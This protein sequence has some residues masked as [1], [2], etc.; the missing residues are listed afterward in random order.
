MRKLLPLPTALAA[1]LL[2]ACAAPATTGAPGIQPRLASVAAAAATITAEAAY[3]H[4]AYLASD[5]MRGRATPSPELE[6]AAQYIAAQFEAAGLRPAG[7]DG[8]YFQRWPLRTRQPRA[9]GALFRLE[10]GGQSTAIAFGSDYFTLVSAQA[11]IQ[12]PP[13]YVGEATTT[14]RSIMIPEGSIPLFLIPGDDLDAH[15]EARASQALAAAVE[16]RAAAVVLILDPAVSRELVQA[17]AGQLSATRVLLPIF[18]VRYQAMAQLLSAAGHDLNT[19]RRSQRAE[20][21]GALLQLATPVASTEAQPPNVVALLPGSDSLLRHTY[22]VYSAHFD[23]VGVGTPDASGDSIYNGADD[24]ASGT[25]A[26]LQLA[27]A[28][29]SLPTPPRR[30]VLFV[31]VSGE[32]LGLLGSQYFVQNPTVPL[33][34]MVAN[35]NMDMVGRNHPDTVAAIGIGYTTLGPL[36]LAIAAALPE[37]GLVVTPDPWPQERLFFRSDHF[38]WAHRGVPAIFFTTGLHPQYH[39]PS[40][41]PEL[42]DADKLARITR[43]VFHL[44]HALAMEPERPRWTPL[45]EREV[46]SLGGWRR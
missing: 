2:A 22:V 37:L 19:L 25:S 12:G 23:H 5:D 40:D 39:R 31:A 9:A 32:E 28:F 33:D 34:S 43:L 20:I 21:P 6:R 14:P 10:A 16:A 15:W 38:S 3:A 46:G 29:A 26:L 24:N 8:T 7:A 42:I 11:G 18:A 1:L 27:R 17:V 45:G 44:G 36:A 30:S 41:R 13:V 35:I 4:V